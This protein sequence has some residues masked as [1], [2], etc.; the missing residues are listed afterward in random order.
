[1]SAKG[2]S[3]FAGIKLTEQT[4]LS[5]GLDQRLFSNTP[6]PTPKPDEQPESQETKKPASQEPGIL[7]TQEAGS[8]ESQEDGK[9]G[10][11][12]VPQQPQRTRRFDLR[13][14]ATEKQTF[15]FSLDEVTA[16][17]DLKLELRRKFDLKTTKYELARLAIHALVGAYEEDGTDSPLL[18]S[19]REKRFP[20]NQETRNSLS[21]ED[22]NMETQETG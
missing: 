11:Q 14:P 5:G 10:N 7:G 9:P 6:R 15:T 17:D 8:L 3:P 18:R 19:L 2:K 21:Q 12:E 13:Q 4:P 20:G 16:L 1:M 22:G